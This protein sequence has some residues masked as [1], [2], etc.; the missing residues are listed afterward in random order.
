MAYTEPATREKHL[1]RSLSQQTCPFLQIRSPSLPPNHISRLIPGSPCSLPPLTKRHPDSPSRILFRTPPIRSHCQFK[2]ISSSAS[3]HPIPIFS[4][5][6]AR[7]KTLSLTRFFSLKL[8]EIN[9]LHIC[10]DSRA[11]NSLSGPT[12]TVATPRVSHR[13]LRLACLVLLP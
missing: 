9:S 12:S 5:L 6:T 2:F 8:N 7:S 3:H 4:F 1:I 10:P 13:H 11:N